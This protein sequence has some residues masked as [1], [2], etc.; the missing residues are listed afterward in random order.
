MKPMHAA[1]LA[2]VPVLVTG[3]RTVPPR[4]RTVCTNPVT[5][6]GMHWKVC[7]TGNYVEYVKLGKG[8]ATQA[9]QKAD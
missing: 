1:V 4:E 8:A 3:C 5:P 6:D 2:L 7:R 9:A